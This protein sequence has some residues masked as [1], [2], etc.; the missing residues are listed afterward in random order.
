VL[1]D[2]GFTTE[3]RAFFDAIRAGR[4]SPVPAAEALEALRTALAAVESARTGR[5]VDLTTWEVS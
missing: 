4:P 5:T 3:L 2:R 1:S